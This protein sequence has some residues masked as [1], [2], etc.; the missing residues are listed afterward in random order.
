MI[1]YN[2]LKRGRNVSR[3]ITQV[4]STQVG[5]MG[6]LRS[7][8]DWIQNVH[9]K[10]C[11]PDGKVKNAPVYIDFPHGMYQGFRSI[12]FNTLHTEIIYM[13]PFINVEIKLSV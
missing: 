11:C 12:F 3:I 10:S 7:A 6:G 4:T 1:A 5:K 2:T 13:S 9:S 8:K